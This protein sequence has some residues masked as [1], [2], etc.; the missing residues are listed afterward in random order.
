M[1]F[2]YFVVCCL[3]WNSNDIIMPNKIH[4][5]LA[6]SVNSL[7]RLAMFPKVFDMH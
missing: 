3:I 1:C 4:R 5:W 6:L 2:E 7:A